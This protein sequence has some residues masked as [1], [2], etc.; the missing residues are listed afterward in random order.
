MPVF[1]GIG[2][3]QHMEKTLPEEISSS[4]VVMT[5]YATASLKMLRALI[6]CICP[7]IHLTCPL[8]MCASSVSFPFFSPVE[9]AM[10]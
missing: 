8:D 2:S 7:N 6:Q 1:S 3:P 5:S 9:A 10:C 4:L